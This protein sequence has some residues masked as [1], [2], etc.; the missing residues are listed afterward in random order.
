MGLENDAEIVN[1][2]LIE[3]SEGLDA[4]DGDLV[5]LEAQPDDRETIDS[6]FRTIHS[7]KGNSSFL[8]FQK[9][10]S[11]AHAGESL[12]SELKE[13]RLSVTSEITTTLLEVVDAIREILAQI[14]QDQAEGDTDYAPLL[15]RLTATQRGDD[16]H[17]DS[18]A[19]SSSQDPEDT[20]L[21][22]IL[23]DR[24]ILSQEDVDAA[25]TLQNQGDPRHIG[26]ILVQ[27]GKLR[28]EEIVDALHEFKDQRSKVPKPRTIRLDVDVL[29]KLL[30]LAEEM[31]PAC[32]Q[33]LECEA[34]LRGSAQRVSRLMEVL[35]EGVIRTR[36]QRIGV[37]WDKLPRVVRDLAL[38]C[39]KQVRIEMEG[40]DT[41][42]DKSIVE[43][44]KDP[45][46]HIIR[47]AI[48]HGIESPEERVAAGKPPEGCLTLRAYHE[49]HQAIIEICDDGAGIDTER[50]RAKAIEKELI[51]R[52]QADALSE[53]E[54]V[55]LVFTPGFST[56]EKVSNISGRGVGMDVVRFNI[57]QFGGAIELTSERGKGS[58]LRISIP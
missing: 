4:L 53:E 19:D 6:I 1:D 37:L 34:A 50:V 8:G 42:L 10:E 18:S 57:E 48:D 38:S 40:A 41:E 28:P 49:D 21:G 23:I 36:L 55:R 9:L 58:T 46:T 25:V 16:E 45:M 30:Q 11:V 31:V 20:R 2:F 17:G 33:L 26:E 12:L 14:E 27:Q 44:L 24:G 5:A 47:N 29:D 7:I 51:T 56:A 54:V 52:E 32:N 39:G 22:A 3:S 13:G 43:A 35:K 15:A